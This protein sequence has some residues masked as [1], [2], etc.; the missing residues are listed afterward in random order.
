MIMIIGYLIKFLVI[1]GDL[2]SLC[3][4]DYSEEQWNKIATHRRKSNWEAPYSDVLNYLTQQ[5]NYLD[6]YYCFK[7]PTKQEE[8]Q[9]QD[10]AES[11]VEAFATVWAKTRID[12]ILLSNHFQPQHVLHYERVKNRETSYTSDHY[13]VVVEI[14]LDNINKNYID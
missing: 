8:T 12:Y 13:P 4:S 6:A 9:P 3:R 7:Q 14:A 10:N 1:I 11:D 2:N 5:K